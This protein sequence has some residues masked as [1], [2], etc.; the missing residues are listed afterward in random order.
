LNATSDSAP[1]QAAPAPRRFEFGLDW[2]LRPL[3]G[4]GL[5]LLAVA[6]AGDG[7]WFFAAFLGA[8][9][10]AAVREWHRIFLGKGYAALF[11]VSAAVIAGALVAQNLLTQASE[12]PLPWILLGIGALLDLGMSRKNHALWNA[13]G[14]LYVGIPPLSLLVLRQVPHGFLL[15]LS[16]FIAVWSTDTGALVTG[17]LI[18]GPKLW[19]RLSPNKTWSGA[20]GGALSAVLCTVILFM[21]V[22]WN[23]EVGALFGLAMSVVGQLGDLFE[24]WIKRRVGRK[25][26][27]SLIPGHGG[28]LDRIDSILFV[29]PLV[30]LAVIGLHFNPMVMP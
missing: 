15:V 19:P 29:A 24:S 12:R 30:T 1:P 18:G 3:F 21:I 28:V 17:N 7:R 22:G 13:F 8:G 20:F 16:V 23:I 5:A 14:V 2:I 25:N 9:S 6:A 27:G 4:V 26:S 11:T 10:I